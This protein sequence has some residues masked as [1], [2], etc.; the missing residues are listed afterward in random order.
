MLH[1]IYV[2]CT[3]PIKTT[4]TNHSHVTL[5]TNSLDIMQYKMTLTFYIVRE[6]SMDV[7]I[8]LKCMVI[9]S[10][11]SMTGCTHQLPFHLIGLHES[12]TFKVA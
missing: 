4:T 2:F 9:I 3:A 8:C 10:D 1:Y 7:F 5:S 6:T 11:S 12:C